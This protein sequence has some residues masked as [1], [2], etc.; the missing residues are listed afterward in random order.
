[1]EG[2]VPRSVDSITFSFEIFE[3]NDGRLKF[4]I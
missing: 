1:M 4:F 3:L 2:N